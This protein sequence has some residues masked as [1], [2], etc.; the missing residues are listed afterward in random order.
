M[1]MTTKRLDTIES[2]VETMMEEVSRI[3]STVAGHSRILEEHTQ[4][5][6]D[7]TERLNRLEIEVK[8]GFRLLRED[9]NRGFERL[10]ILLVKAVIS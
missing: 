5:L 8:E 4:I 2:Y 1:D 6:S 7:H 9:M 3:D 10:G